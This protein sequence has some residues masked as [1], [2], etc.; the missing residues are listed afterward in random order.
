[1]LICVLGPDY[2]TRSRSLR[3][4]RRKI[5]SITTMRSADKRLHSISKMFLLLM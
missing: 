5:A 1:M 3:C 2:G 4:D